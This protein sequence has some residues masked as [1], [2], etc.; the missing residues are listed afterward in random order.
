[1]HTVVSWSSPLS[2]LFRLSFDKD[3]MIKKALDLMKLY[4]AAGIG[5]DRVLIKVCCR[6]CL[7]LFLKN[8]ASH[9]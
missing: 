4:E 2:F 3:A 5:K 9:L 8:L 7:F 1:M 6:L